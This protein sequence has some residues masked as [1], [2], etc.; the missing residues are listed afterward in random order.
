MNELLPT[1]ITSTVEEAADIKT[2]R[3]RGLRHID[4]VE[5]SDAR[6]DF[7]WQAHINFTHP[8]TWT[9]A[10]AKSVFLELAASLARAQSFVIIHSLPDEVVPSIL[11]QLQEMAEYEVR[12]WRLREE[13]EGPEIR[14]RWI[15]LPVTT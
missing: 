4:S 9:E 11:P 7:E 8:G 10:E 5:A 6:I 15:S 12:M 2:W 13:V 3:I 14:E 1:E